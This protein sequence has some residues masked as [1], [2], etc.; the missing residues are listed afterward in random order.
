MPAPQTIPTAVPLRASRVSELRKLEREL[1]YTTARTDIESFIAP[2][3]K[4]GC[5]SGWW[6]RLSSVEDRSE[7]QSVTKAVRYLELRKLLRRH[8]LE[9]D[10]VRVLR[11]K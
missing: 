6:Y 9:P 3:R 8:P 1:A 2:V 5:H 11:D 10:L 7:K 4:S